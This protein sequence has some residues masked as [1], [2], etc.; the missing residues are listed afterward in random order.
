MMRPLLLKGGRVI[1]P[2]RG[3]DQ[4]A[5]ILIQDGAIAAV[6]TGLGT[7]DGP[8]ARGRARPP[9]RARQ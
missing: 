6:G 1:D 8:R 4:V 9:A 2:S 3:L 7:P 5:D